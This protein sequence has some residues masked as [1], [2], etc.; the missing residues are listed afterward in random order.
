MNIAV[1][2]GGLYGVTDLVLFYVD[3]VLMMA[4]CIIAVSAPSC[5]FDF[6]AELAVVPMDVVRER[7]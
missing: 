1:H 2:T 7:Q 3:F 5:L 6:K 4:Y